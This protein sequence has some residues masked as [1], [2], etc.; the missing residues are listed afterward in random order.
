M[1]LEELKAKVP[2]PFQGF[3]ATYGPVVLTWA[4]ADFEAWLQLLI[5][6]DIY[7]AYSQVLK[8]MNNQQSV[9]EWANINEQWKNANAD[10]AARASLAKAALVELLKIILG[11][12]ALA[13]GL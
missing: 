11:I 10:N 1:T 12:A 8:G 5:K 3:V 7:A 9:D 4:A 13:V 2:A 6:G